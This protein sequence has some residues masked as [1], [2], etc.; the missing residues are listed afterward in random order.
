MGKSASG[1]VNGKPVQKRAAD[2]C[3]YWLRAL[4]FTYAI[5]TSCQL[6][7]V[8]SA[9][10]AARLTK[11][12]RF[13]V[14]SPPAPEQVGGDQLD[15]VL[16]VPAELILIDH[17]AAVALRERRRDRGAALSQRRHRARQRPRLPV[18]RRKGVPH[19]P[20]PRRQV[21]CQGHGTTEAASDYATPHAISNRWFV[22]H[23]HLVCGRD[24]ACMAHGLGHI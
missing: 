13:A 22:G 5:A 14:I 8:A 17:L 23:G 2:P 7:V 18:V 15:V 6:L 19:H 9:F 21:A 16:P 12:S 10:S 3:V 1:A 20:H 11:A 4:S 24:A